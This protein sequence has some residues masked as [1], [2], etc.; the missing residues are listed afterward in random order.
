MRWPT[1]SRVEASGVCTRDVLICN[2]KE[3]GI[4]IS[5]KLLIEVVCLFLFVFST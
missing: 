2:R 1:L 5:L 4:N 3:N